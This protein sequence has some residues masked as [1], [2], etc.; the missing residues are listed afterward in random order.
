MGLTGWGRSGGIV[1]TWMMDEGVGVG[2][3][4]DRVMKGWMED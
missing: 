4:S 3:R 1:T 2:K